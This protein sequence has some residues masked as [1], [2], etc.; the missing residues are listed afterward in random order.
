[1]KELSITQEY[2]ICAVNEKGKISGFSTEKLVC[3]VASALL[4]M[5]L[6][7]CVSMDG[8]KVTVTGELPAGKSYLR[9]LYDFINRPKPVKLEKVLEEY[10]CTV[11][12]KRLNEL[13]EAVGGSLEEMGLAES[14]KAGILGGKKSYTPAKAALDDII[15][16]LRAA[17]LEGGQVT[18][19]IAVLVTLLDKSKCLKA[20][21][22]DNER[23]EI[24]T[25]LKELVNTPD[26]KLIKEMID[27]V[28]GM[29]V[30]MVAA[31]SALGI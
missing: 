30:A 10:N 14:A 12:D 13:M 7:G 6:S 17:I 22:P 31:I 20:Y 21:F 28:D 27:Y 11:T 2:L 15:G 5:Q 25:K 29:I 9:P 23:R 3:F 8:K 4:D 16:S 26:G 19:E 1:M 24:G 18:K